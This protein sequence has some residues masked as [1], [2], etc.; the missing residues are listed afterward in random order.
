MGTFY[1]SR[2]LEW[3]ECARTELLRNAGIPYADMERKGLLLPL[4]EA[5]INFV[6]RARY[7]D[8][9]T[10]TTSAA[11]AGKASVRFEVSIVNNTANALII[12][13]YTVHAV[14]DPAGKPI[15][16]PNWI[17]NALTSPDP[18]CNFCKG[19][20]CLGACRD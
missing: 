2:A 10:L 20:Q 16:L 11:P 6:G 17:V 3:F 1:N 5:H 15:R 14:T 8:Q 9:L 13:G 4:V 19:Q 12:T 7:D 18:N